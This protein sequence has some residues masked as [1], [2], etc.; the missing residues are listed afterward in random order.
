MTELSQ[1]LRDFLP[2]LTLSF[3]IQRHHTNAQLNKI[4]LLHLTVGRWNLKVL[5]NL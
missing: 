2:T 3:D 4:L 1:F 5:I